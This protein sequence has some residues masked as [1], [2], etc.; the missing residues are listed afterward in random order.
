MISKSLKVSYNNS[1]NPA[2]NFIHVYTAILQIAVMLQDR[3]MLVHSL[4]IVEGL[5]WNTK[6]HLFCLKF[7]PTVMVYYD[8]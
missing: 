8:V 4:L 3:L 5:Q 1:I 7:R 2:I 6:V